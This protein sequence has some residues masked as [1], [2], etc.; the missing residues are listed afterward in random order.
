[1]DHDLGH[2]SIGGH[3]QRTHN[4]EPNLNKTTPRGRSPT[5]PRGPPHRTPPHEN[6]LEFEDNLDPWNYGQPRGTRD[7]KGARDL[8]QIAL[9]AMRV[10]VS[11]FDGRLDPKVFLD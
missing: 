8:K 7:H 6:I 1:M 11:T 10:D 4:P 3:R 2:G 9:K 5:P